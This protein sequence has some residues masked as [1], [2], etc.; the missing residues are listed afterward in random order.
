MRAV[1]SIVVLAG[2]SHSPLTAL[3]AVW[4]ETRHS[5]NAIPE[6]KLVLSAAGNALMALPSCDEDIALCKAGNPIEI[7]IREDGKGHCIFR[8]LILKQSLQLKRDS[9]ELNLTLRHD[10][11][12]LVNTRRSRVFEQQ[13]EADMIGRSLFEQKIPAIHI[14]A[15][16]TFH[17]QLVQFCC[18]DWYFIRCRANA[19]GAWL[20]P[21][22]DGLAIGSPVLAVTP[23][24]TLNQR[25]SASE[26]EPLIEEGDWSF[27]EQYQPSRLNVGIWD[28]HAQVADSVS[29]ALTS[30]GA[31]SFD[32][33]RGN[34]LNSSL[35]EFNHSAPLGAAQAA[36]LSM[37]LLMNLRAAATHGRF[38]VTGGTQYRLGQ[39]LAV[40]G[41]GRSFDGK[42]VITDIAHRLNKEEGWTTTLSLG[43]EDIA[44]DLPVSPRAT[45]LHVGVV[46]SFQEDRSGMTR[47]RVRLPVLGSTHNELWARL[48]SPYASRMSGFCFYPEAGDEVV[49][50]FFDDDPSYPVILGSMH[51]PVNRAPIAPDARNNLKALVVEK[52]G[53]RMQVSFDTLACSTTMNAADHALTLHD[54]AALKSAT[55]VELKATDIAVEG[56]QTTLSGKGAVTIRGATIDLSH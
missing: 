25:T 33:T 8:G 24:H 34:R 30:L 22:P 39:T 43:I 41:Y 47:L 56:E 45:G 27:S 52:D 9:V 10:L 44:G 38:V 55:R 53:R 51:N 3:H 54:G 26:G 28:D 5:V 13:K 20:F 7:H 42:G 6:A 32:A 21:S 40:D 50:G 31:Q 35:W 29:A 19:N 11:H 15:M 48:A 23:D 16:D 46:A 12:K 37:G 18:S 14:R 1:P 4:I 36:T 17:D 2:P 49:V